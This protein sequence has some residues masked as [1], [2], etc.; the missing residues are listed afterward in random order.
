MVSEQVYY[1][2]MTIE[3]DLNGACTTNVCM[4]SG[5]K[6][7]KGKKHQ[8]GKKEMHP[9]VTPRQALTSHPPSTVRESDKEIGEYA[10]DVTT[11]EEWVAKGRSGKTSRRDIRPAH[12]RDWQQVQDP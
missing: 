11:I 9:K 6:N 4:G 2:R 12:E 3:G 1:K 10:I 7:R 5:K 8:K